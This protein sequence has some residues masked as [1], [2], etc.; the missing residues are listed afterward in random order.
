MSMHF[1]PQWVKPIKPTGSTQATTPTALNGGIGSGGDLAS[2]SSLTGSK[3]S[4]PFPALGGGGA[5]GGRA[6]PTTATAPNPALSYSRATY[7]PQSPNVADTS[8]FPDQDHNPGNPHPFRY[9]RDQILGLYDENKFKDVP[10]ELLDLLDQNGILVSKQPVKP[11]GLREL[12][13]G[14]KKVSQL[15]FDISNLRHRT[16]Y[17]ILATNIHPQV[18][19]SRPNTST[20][21]NSTPSRRS[22]PSNKDPL[23]M[24]NGS[25]IGRF[26]QGQGENSFGTGK[27]GT[28][29]AIGGAI[30]GGAGSAETRDREAR[31]PGAI[32]GGFGG[33]GKRIGL[34]RRQE[35]TDGE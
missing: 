22:N 35:S 23:S 18:T 34:G 28:I 3:P 26:G 17:Q 33:V 12:T 15:L 6:S 24:S 27:I 1:V 5:N 4:Q 9:S 30:G 32:G 14:E 7:T 11:V 13:E 2:P 8:Y 21:D 20:N 10:M 25:R 19:R 29:G 16:H 31:A